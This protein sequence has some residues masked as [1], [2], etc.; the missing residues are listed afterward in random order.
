[1]VIWT[2]IQN[3]ENHFRYR[4]ITLISEI[5]CKYWKHKN[6]FDMY[7]RPPYY[8]HAHMNLCNKPGTIKLIDSFVSFRASVNTD[9]LLCK[10]VI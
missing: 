2:S 5:I 6:A 7:T 4:A 8:T 10:C 3:N 1:M 9:K